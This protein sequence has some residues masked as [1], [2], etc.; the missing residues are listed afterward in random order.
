MQQHCHLL[1]AF[2]HA[3]ENWAHTANQQVRFIFLLV[4][5]LG[6]NVISNIQG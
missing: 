4:V 6:N 1:L 3:C 5:V 2:F